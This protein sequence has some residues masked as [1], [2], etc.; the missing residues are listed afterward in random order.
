MKRVG[1]IGGMG[2]L[3]SVDL[4]SKI[5]A[6]T[7]AK[8][9][10]DHI[11]LTIDNN[12]L[13]P[14]RS[15]YIFRKDD[16]KENPLPYLIDSAKRLENSGCDAFCLAC[17]TAHYFADDILKHTKMEFLNMPRIAVKSIV[18][19]YPKA[20]N[21]AI[22]GT[23]STRRSGIYDKFLN[24]VGLNSVEF[25]HDIEQ[26]IMDSI[27]K[28]VKAGKTSEYVELFRDTLRHIKADIFVAACTE[29]PIFI[30]YLDGE[31]KFVDATNE[32]A[33]EIVRFAKS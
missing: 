26:N 15:E 21:I 22:V 4:Y 27:Y 31:F 5:V 9:D 13:V 10:Q 23:I 32:L 18:K 7:P 1:I 19:D 28:G 30:P 14:D 6:L 2:S 33:K 20:K 25:S 24:E 8:C 29:I 11:L 17:N 3:A 12:A 16:S